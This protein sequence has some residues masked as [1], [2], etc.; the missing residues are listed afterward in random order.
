[1]DAAPQNNRWAG[2]GFVAARAA[3]MRVSDLEAKAATSPRLPAPARWRAAG[4]GGQVAQIGMGVLR[5]RRYR[6]GD[7]GEPGISLAWCTSP[8]SS[9]LAPISSARPAGAELH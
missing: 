2:R 1:M 9:S 8:P 4:G 7:G 6:G 3:A 5:G